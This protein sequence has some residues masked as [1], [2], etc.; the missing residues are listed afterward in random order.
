[1]KTSRA[2]IVL[3][4][5]AFLTFSFAVAVG[6][7]QALKG[8]PTS[9]GVIDVEKVFNSL[10]EKVQIEADLT[11]RQ[12]NLVTER[13][14]REKELK[15]LKNEL[16]LLSPANSGF[17]KKQDELEKKV[18]DLQ[19]WM[20]WQNASLVRENRLQITQLY[21]KIVAAAGK[22]AK[23]NG[24]DLVLFKETSTDFSNVDPKELSAA[25]RS[26]KVLWSAADLDVTDQL[27]TTMNNEFKNSVK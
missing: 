20:Q 26:R 21:S 4:A 15:S 27:V 19:S 3:G 1:M 11:T 23:E 17:K 22:I 12:Q 18:F 25:L 13:N 7:A 16:D 10:Q 14:D 2:W 5:A 8:R 6:A 24:Y 9:V